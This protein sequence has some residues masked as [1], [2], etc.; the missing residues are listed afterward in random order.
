MGANYYFKDTNTD[1]FLLYQVTDGEE[2]I[3]GDYNDL[4][5]LSAAVT[6]ISKYRSHYTGSKFKIRKVRVLVEDASTTKD[7]D[8]Y[9]KELVVKKKLDLI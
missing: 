5:S 2:Q 9:I 3:Y 1:K 6:W 8:K 7:E 4:R